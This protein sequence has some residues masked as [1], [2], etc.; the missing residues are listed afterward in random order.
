MIS[1]LQQVQTQS[2]LSL[3][4]IFVTAIHHQHD[5]YKRNFGCYQESNKRKRQNLRNL[6]DWRE[7][8][9]FT[10][11]TSH[12]KHR[13]TFQYAKHS[14]GKHSIVIKYKMKFMENHEFEIL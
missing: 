13:Q 5:G 1:S 2:S 9:V 12:F 11:K 8:H 4:L 7:E 6:I 10:G 14:T 3:S